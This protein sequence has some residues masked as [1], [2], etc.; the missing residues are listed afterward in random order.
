MLS[1]GDRIQVLGRI[2]SAREAGIRQELKPNPEG[3][4]RRAEEAT[5]RM[6]YNYFC[7]V[8]QRLGYAR[9]NF[10]EI[11]ACVCAK[12]T[13]QC[14]TSKM[15][16]D[17][18]AAFGSPPPSNKQSH[19]AEDPWRQLANADDSQPWTE[20][21]A[22]QPKLSGTSDLA[23][24]ADNDDDD[25]GDFE[26]ASVTTTAQPTAE[27]PDGVPSRASAASSAA[28]K[29]SSRSTQKPFPPKAP[30][31]QPAKPAAK[32]KD[33]ARHPFANHMDLL[34]ETGDDEYDAG[35]DELADLSNNP[36]AAMAYSKRIIAEQQAAQEKSQ[37]VVRKQPIST[38]VPKSEPKP[39]PNKLRKKSGY[40]PPSR[41]AEV[42]FDADT[43]SAGEDDDFG[44][45]EDWQETA[46]HSR[47]PSKAKATQKQVAMPALDLLG[48]D[49]APEVSSGYDST[50]KGVTS[51][52]P[53][54][55]K[56]AQERVH[57]NPQPNLS[58][59]SA[60]EDDE[61]ADFETTAPQSPPI[62]TPSRPLPSSGPNTHRSHATVKPEL[63]P[64]TNI[65]T[66]IMLLSLFSPLFSSAD[67]ALFDTLS[68]LDL[69]QRQALLA[70]P[71]S[72]Q[73]LR[74][75]LGHCGVLA[76]IVAGRKLRWKR[77]QRLSQN[78][79]I[80]PAAAGGK[81]GMK[82]TGLDKT[83]VAKEDREVVDV[84]RLWKGQV[85]KLRTAV[86]AASA[87]PGL[88]K[89]PHVPEIAEQM[90]VKTLKQTEGGIMAPHACALCGLRREERVAKVDVEIEDSFGE[91]WVQGMN[92][93]VVCR[94]FWEEF[95]RKLKS[96]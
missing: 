96:R 84:L 10:D 30:P 79:R 41:N 20:P 95:E 56:S 52:K 12:T 2:A 39:A 78:M 73:F 57:Q 15:S 75:Y 18:F 53:S 21:N 13:S 74:G 25:F 32:P 55:L 85:G 11:D 72:H 24:Q 86:T 58:S 54:D 43:V 27:K 61:W 77:D 66:P 65:P 33:S 38:A 50:S 70:H 90:P 92:M 48:L 19:E 3:V 93:H 17:L 28:S 88:P 4:A 36:E 82:L 71:A 23:S 60:A 59:V 16:N 14:W 91:W 68:K 62:P 34:F 89:L 40:A 94:K 6:F 8:Q 37:P 29:T 64:P 45:F 80:G 47:T 76:H 67:D 69:K 87:T 7:P 83:E 9:Q 81:G 5:T 49:E 46:I 42:L 44:D 63:L 22:K 51:P 1:D 31:S 26:D 35:A